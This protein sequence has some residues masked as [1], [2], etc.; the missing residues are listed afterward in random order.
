MSHSE[1]SDLL[2]VFGEDDEVDLV[3][4]NGKIVF[5]KVNGSVVLTVYR[6]NKKHGLGTR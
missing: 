3:S 4:Y 6:R 2:V 5:M 1:T